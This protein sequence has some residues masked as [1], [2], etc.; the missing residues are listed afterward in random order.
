MG[1]GVVA[2][3]NSNGSTG[4]S[5]RSLIHS[6]ILS[7]VIEEFELLFF[8]PLKSTHDRHTT[9]RKPAPFAYSPLGKH[10]LDPQTRLGD[11]LE[12]LRRRLYADHVRNL[13]G[14]ESTMLSAKRVDG[15]VDRVDVARRELSGGRV[16][17]A[18][19]VCVSDHV[20][21][22]RWRVWCGIIRDLDLRPRHS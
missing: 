12:L 20:Q 22:F 15:A 13:L 11:R 17:Y 19:A 14:R 2:E 8:Q 16:E 10:D 5:R 6:W 1:G 21:D 7:R 18:R 9:P 3:V 4:T